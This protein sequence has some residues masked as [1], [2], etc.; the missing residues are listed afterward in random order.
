MH[1]DNLVLS[2]PITLEP[3]GLTALDMHP[4]Q[5]A[6]R[7]RYGPRYHVLDDALRDVASLWGLTLELGRINA[8]GVFTPLD[9]VLTFHAGR[10]RAEIK[11]AELPNGLCAKSTSHTLSCSGASSAPSVWNPVAFLS[12]DD[13]R[14][15]S[16]HE[17]RQRFKAVIGAGDSDAADARSILDQIDGAATPQ[18]E[19]F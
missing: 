10:C 1:A 9:E 17:H 6:I 16:L 11:L 2:P 4:G 14:A 7:A 19:L 18:L 13:A 3:L 5:H 8:H 12:I 15:A